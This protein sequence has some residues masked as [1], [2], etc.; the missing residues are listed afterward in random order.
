MKRNEEEK[1]LEKILDYQN[2]SYITRANYK[3]KLSRCRTNAS[4]ASIFFE[5]NFVANLIFV[6]RLD[7]LENLLTSLIHRLLR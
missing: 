3:A 4:K 7:G 6:M 1:S 5:L 2:L